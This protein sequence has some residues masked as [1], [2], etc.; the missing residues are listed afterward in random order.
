M[1][2]GRVDLQQ[3]RGVNEKAFG[4][5]KEMVG[6]LVGNERLQREGEAQQEKAAAELTALRK[7]V[8]AQAADA[9]VE[10]LEKRQETAQRAKESAE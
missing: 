9:K 10:V 4:L 2:I 5:G 3:L 8:E 1:R 7:D 6:V